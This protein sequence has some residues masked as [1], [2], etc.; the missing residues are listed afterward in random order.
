M[1][2]CAARAERAQTALCVVLTRT[3]VKAEDTKAM[4]YYREKNGDRDNWTKKS[5]ENES[6]AHEGIGI[7]EGKYKG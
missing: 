7:G 1:V 6:R 2:H 3:P 5:N 4:V